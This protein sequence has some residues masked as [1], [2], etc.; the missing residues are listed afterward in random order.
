MI[1]TNK[2]SYH[3]S[4]LGRNISN[5]ITISEIYNTVHIITDTLL[6]S[7]QLNIK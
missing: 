7:A 6:E 3:I 2:I 4:F 5:N 1:L